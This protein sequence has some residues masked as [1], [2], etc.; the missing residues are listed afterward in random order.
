MVS[1]FAV[2]HDLQKDVENVRMGFFNLIKQEHTMRV[3]IHTVGQ[4]AAL[5]EANIARRCA[6]QARDSVFFHIF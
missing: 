5:V 2:V 3:L 1:E 6:Y 4:Q